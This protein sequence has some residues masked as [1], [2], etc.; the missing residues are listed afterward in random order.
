MSPVKRLRPVAVIHST[1]IGTRVITAITV[2]IPSHEAGAVEDGE[3]IIEV[4]TTED[5]AGVEEGTGQ[6]IMEATAMGEAEVMGMGVGEAI[7]MD[8]EGGSN[9]VMIVSMCQC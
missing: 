6:I 4:T 5:E 1:R 9:D 7:I 3:V 2:T 8:T